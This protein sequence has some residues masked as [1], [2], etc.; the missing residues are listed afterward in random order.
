MAFRNRSYEPLP[1]S[2]PVLRQQL[3]SLRSAIVHK[4]PFCQGLAPLAVDDLV[5]FYGK[6]S[7][8]RRINLL[9][10]SAEELQHLAETCDPATFGVDQQDVYDETYRKAGKL[11]RTDFALANFSPDAVGILDEVRNELLIEGLEKSERI[12]AELYKLNVYGPGSFFKAHVDTPRSERM[13]GS[14]VIVFPTAHEGGELVLRQE[15]EDSDDSNTEDSEDPKQE[16]SEDTEMKDSS[17]PH[18]DEWTFDSSALLSSAAQ[19]ESSMPAS[20]PVAYVAF[21]SDVE[22]E[23]LPVRSGY[24]VTI[25]YNLYYEQD[26]AS[27]S[28]GGSVVPRSV[29]PNEQTFKSTFKALLDDPTFLPTGGN[30]LFTFLHQYPLPRGSK[31]SKAALQDVRFRL[32]GSDAV[33]MKVVQE[34][35]LNATLGIVYQDVPEYGDVNYVLCDEVVSLEGEEV[36]SESLCEFLLEDSDAVVLN[37]NPRWAKMYRR[38]A[39][40][41]WIATAPWRFNSNK[42]TFVAHGN[43]A[44]LSHTYWRISMLVRVG[45]AGSRAVA[46]ENVETPKA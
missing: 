14:L 19:T 23:V 46:V 41:H 30:L 27:A 8:A 42:E 44:T 32:K 28:G 10:A 36:W 34:F 3:G 37:P 25:T 18:K 13:F 12:H 38:T 16:D 4:P 7:N 5:L 21:Y 31:A 9:N 11:D 1:P 29:P 22:H 43:E 2:D 26:P 20:A 35:H 39:Q 45:A 40:V 33:I 15:K 6:G 24:R 17:G